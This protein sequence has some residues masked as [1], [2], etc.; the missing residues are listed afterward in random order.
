MSYN[1]LMRAL[2]AFAVVLAACAGQVASVE[3]Q[4]LAAAGWSGPPPHVG[5]SLTGSGAAPADS[6]RCIAAV[7]GA[8][9]IVDGNAPVQALVTVEP[10]GNRL[11]ITSLRRGL[12]RDEARPAWPV[13]HLCNDALFAL[14]KVLRTETPYVEPIES[15][16]PAN[17]RPYST[18]SA[19]GAIHRGPGL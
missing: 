16:A 5:L 10:A 14:V 2:S 7:T 11:Q 3:N 6:E 13:E 8:G 19:S 1:R 15:P 4:P 18:P 17:E 12:V 9:A